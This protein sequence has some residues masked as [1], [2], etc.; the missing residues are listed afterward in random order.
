VKDGP[1]TRSESAILIFHAAFIFG[2]TLSS[3]DF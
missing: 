1:E 2:R 3:E